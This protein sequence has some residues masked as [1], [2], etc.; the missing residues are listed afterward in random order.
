MERNTFYTLP[1]SV[2]LLVRLNTLILHHS[3]NLVE[4]P[5]LPQGLVE[6]D[7]SHCP[8]LEKVGN[9]SP[10]N[11]LEVLIT[12]NCKKVFELPGL[13]TLRSLKELNLVGCM[14]LK[15]LDNI[16]QLEFLEKM[17][18]NNCPSSIMDVR[19]WIKVC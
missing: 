8:K 17:Y 3:E 13:W 19:G 4:L 10:L 9:L 1:S 5:I 11:K 12:C 15:T 6:V 7:V 2:S 18:V 16:E 14:N